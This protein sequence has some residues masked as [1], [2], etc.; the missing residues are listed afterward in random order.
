MK[1]K[2]LLLGGGGFIGSHVARIFKREDIDL[3][4]LDNF[5]T[6]LISRVENVHVYVNG[7]ASNKDLI[8]SI[9][10]EYG[11]TGIINMAAFMQARESVSNPIKYWRNNLGVAL[12]IADALYELNIKRVILSSSCSVYGNALNAT[13]ETNLNPLSPYASTKV[14]SEQV[15]SQACTENEVEFASLRYFNVIGGGDFPDSIDTK[16]ETLVPSVCRKI[17]AGESP[18][19]YGGDFPTKDGTCERDYIDVRDL[20]DAH[21]KICLI[22][23]NLRDEYINISTGKCITVLEV[24][25]TIL[26]TSSSKLAPVIMGAKKGDPASVSAL[27]SRSLKEIGWTP[28]YELV[29]SIESHWR[30]FTSRL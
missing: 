30:A 22:D 21:L 18:L 3:V 6:G 2:W 4:V 7:D 5:S 11:I 16:P 1:S 28:R 8:V 15:L 14:A 17:L 23:R 9:C 26:N 25:K 10:K 13:S 12:A 29:E 20:A 24:V 19:I 27:P